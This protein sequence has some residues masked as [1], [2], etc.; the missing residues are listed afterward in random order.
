MTMIG[1]FGMG[2]FQSVFSVLFA[3]GFLVFLGIFLAVSIRS[4]G[5][6]NKNNRSPRLTVGA[7]A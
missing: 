6:W 7:R 1:S 5:Q 3:L 2:G 4:L